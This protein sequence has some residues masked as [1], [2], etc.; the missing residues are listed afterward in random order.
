MGMEPEL[1]ILL[2]DLLSISRYT[3]KD[4]YGNPSYG[5]AL[6][7]LGRVDGY[8]VN[9]EGSDSH[10]QF[11]PTPRVNVSIIMDYVSPPFGVQDKIVLEDGTT[12][13]I[14]T[15]AIESDENGPYYMDISAQTQ[16]EL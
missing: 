16:E 3:G 8:T 11:A 14:T 4:Q 2:Q 5:S 7:Y 15:I 12:V 13:Y 10:D 6:T 1:A 9:R